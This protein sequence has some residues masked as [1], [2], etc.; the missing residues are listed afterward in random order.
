[1]L[2]DLFKLIFNVIIKPV[3]SAETCICM[4]TIVPDTL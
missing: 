3:N 1:M 4:Q 2:G